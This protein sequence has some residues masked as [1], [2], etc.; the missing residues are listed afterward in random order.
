M[1]RNGRTLCLLLLAACPLATAARAQQHKLDVGLKSL[2]ATPERALLMETSAREGARRIDARLEKTP[3]HTDGTVSVKIRAT[4]PQA[5]AAAVRGLGGTAS[6]VQGSSILTARLPLAS[7]RRLALNGSVERIELAHRVR[8]TNGLAV[9]AVNADDVH[10]GTGL[11]RGY[12]GDGVVVG[13]IDTGIDWSHF[14]FT[15]PADPFSSRVLAIWDQN[16]LTGPPPSGFGYGTLWTRAQIEA[17]LAGTT[18]GVVRHKDE[19]GHGTHVAGSAA[20]TG[21]ATG[22]HA[23]VAHESDIIMVATN[24]LDTGIVDGAHFVFD[25]AENLGLPAAVNASLGTHNGPHDGTSLM[26]QALD[27][28]VSEGTGKAFLAAG[29]NEGS[30]LIH[31]GTTSLTEAAAYL[32]VWQWSDLFGFPEGITGL[33][34]VVPTSEVANI[35]FSFAA[36]SAGSFTSPTY[37]ASLDATDWYSVEEA[38]AS[39]FG[40]I[41]TLRYA[42][43]QY[44]AS[45]YISASRIDD[46]NTEVSLVIADSLW[47]DGEDEFGYPMLFGAELWRLRVRGAGWI[48][49]W[50]QDGTVIATDPASRYGAPVDAAFLPGNND[51]SIG[52]PADGNLVIAVGAYTNRDYSDDCGSLLAGDLACFSS[53]GPTVDG[54]TKPDFAAPGHRVTSVLSQQVDQSGLNPDDVSADG[55]HW[56]ISGTSMATPVATGATALL[57]EQRPDLTIDQIRDLLIDNSASD[58]QT[59]SV[60][61]NDWGSGKLDILA[62]MQAGTGSIS[63]LNQSP[64]FIAALPDTSVQSA[65]GMLSFRFAATDP[66][67]SDIT[68]RSPDLPEAAS[69]NSETGLFE[70]QPVSGDAGLWVI[71]VWASDGALSAVSSAT[72]TVTAAPNVAPAFTATLPD[73]TIF[74]DSFLSFTFQASDANLDELMLEMT[75]GPSEASLTESFD[76]GEAEFFWNPSPS[77]L[78]EHVVTVTVSDG[79]LTASSSATVTV[80]ETGGISAPV[81]SAQLPDTTIAVGIALTFQYEASDGSGFDPLFI[82]G[83]APLEA[84]VSETGLLTWTPQEADVGTNTVEVIAIGPGGDATASAVVTVTS[85]GGG[86]SNSAP[87]FTTVLPDTTVSVGPALTFQ[88]VAQDADADALSFAM[89]SGPLGATLDAGTGAFAWTP[90]ASDVGDHQLAVTVSDGQAQASTASTITVQEA[91]SAPAFTTVLPDTTIATGATLLFVYQATDP[92]GDPVQY[93]LVNGPAGMLVDGG[94]GALAWTPRPTQA[95]AHTVTVQASDG[96]LSTQVTSNVDVVSGVSVEEEDGLPEHPVLGTPFPN[97]ARRGVTIRLDLPTPA[98]GRLALYDGLGREVRVVRNEVIPAGRTLVSIPTG[99][100]VAGLYHYVLEVEGRRLVTHF[101]VVR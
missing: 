21:A 37:L 8:P 44:A 86:G 43:G 49:L 67:G 52:S 51:Y 58:I 96:L 41:D 13:I 7:V 63:M 64:V 35:E 50:Q 81:F 95:G 98:H 31:W 34:G 91:N 20:G 25:M 46:R 42:N 39:S 4:A 60:P 57:L 17:E 19:D 93:S 61:N 74:P 24:F 32:E 14:D 89:T 82:P 73:T 101:V 23:G 6:V 18:S 54:R 40:V 79:E 47:Q 65:P 75:T 15:D 12:T 38:M 78:G 22:E 30:S 1:T 36:D 70:W 28:L 83:V 3:W 69:L 11:S 84:A 90:G 88:F 5:A 100:L 56:T 99:D 80:S 55:F 16:D 2:L 29:G 94:S 68:F 97:P 72:I 48:H 66:E 59:G 27:A 45:V 87:A 76:P 71:G 77:D 10:A 26:D 62:S 92:N 85:A 33:T 53:R 9:A